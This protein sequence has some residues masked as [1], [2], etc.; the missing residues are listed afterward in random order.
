MPPPPPPPASFF[1]HT[2]PLFCRRYRDAAIRFDCRRCFED[3][4]HCFFVERHAD[5]AISAAAAATSLPLLAIFRHA[6]ALPP[7]LALPAR[8][9]AASAAAIDYYAIHMFTP[10]AIAD[11]D[12]ADFSRMLFTPSPPA[13]AI[14]SFAADAASSCH[15][16][17]F[18]RFADTL[19][20]CFTTRR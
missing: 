14:S 4:Y 2:M 10:Y 12:A 16:M 9:A 11:A 6:A 7:L 5:G 8:L 17:L 3:R 18:R 15:A 13:A 19:L 20:R 1:L